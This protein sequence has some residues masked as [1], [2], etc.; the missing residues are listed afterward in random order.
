M[1]RLKL[2]NSVEKRN[3]LYGGKTPSGTLV[4]I[5]E[6]YER[7]RRYADALEFFSKAKNDAGVDRIKAK[8]I[9]VGHS[10]VLLRVRRIGPRE[11]SPEEWMRAAEAAEKAGRFQDALHCLQESGDAAKLEALRERLRASDVGGNGSPPPAPA[12]APKPPI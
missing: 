4:E 11:I 9:E 12:A 6:L 2:P 5:G 7:E 1:A 3:L 8:A 10:F